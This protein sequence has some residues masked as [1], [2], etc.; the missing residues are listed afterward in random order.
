M[1]L[2]AKIKLNPTKEQHA[3]LL[4]TLECANSACNYI[5]QQ[6]WEAKQFG[7]VPVHKL[8]YHPVR[9]QFGRSAQVAIRCIGKVVD[10]YK[11]DRKVMRTFKPH[12]SIA[13]DSRILTYKRDEQ[14]V[15][16][17]TIA[18]RQTIPF[19][20]GERQLELLPYQQ[21]ESDLAYIKGQWFL[22]ATCDIEEPTP[23]DV[24]EYLGVDLGVK[25]I[26]VDSDGEQ[27]S[28]SHI[29]KVRIRYAK[30]RAK[31]QKKGT[32]SAKRLLK[33][34][35]GRESRFINDVNH[36]IS[37]QL[38]KKAQGTQRGIALE[39]L[40]GIRSRVTVRK[41]QRLLLHSWSFHDLR[42]KIDYKA[43]RYSVPITY[44]DPRNTSREC[45]VCGCVDK[46]NRETQDKFSCI[47]CGHVAHADYNAAINI[48]R[49]A[50]VNKPYAV[51]ELGA[52]P[53]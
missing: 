36:C 30:L 9:E 37:K 52:N 27:H 41:S 42:R 24:D 46:R 34:R 29:N 48:S 53:A 25:N 23:D 32:K 12:G 16:I 44:V 50:S 19:Q 13:Y 10:A 20:A 39:D 22:F 38:V 3:L 5:S 21:G 4:E 40:V 2:T 35:S 28:A 33:K 14:S 31:L 7:R 11:L 51:S 18:G 26:A 8:T 43:Q 15:S 47:Q 1:K 49:R 17:W 6:A 45:S